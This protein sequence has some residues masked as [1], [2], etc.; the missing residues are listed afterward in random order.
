MKTLT[1]HTSLVGINVQFE[2]GKNWLE[3]K[4]CGFF[5]KLNGYHSLQE[6]THLSCTMG[7][8]PCSTM[9]RIYYGSFVI[10]ICFTLAIL[11]QL[12]GASFLYFY[13]YTAPQAKIRKWA[14][15]FMT[16]GPCLVVAGLGTWTVLTPD[17]G[18]LPRGWVQL[19]SS[20][21]GNSVLGYHTLN[22][23]Q[24]GWSFVLAGFVV[25]MM[26]IQVMIF[27]CC[28]RAHW[29]EEQ[30]DAEE[31]DAEQYLEYELIHSE[32][33][34]LYGSVQPDPASHAAMHGSI[35]SPQA[36]LYG[37]HEAQQLQK[38]LFPQQQWY[39]QQQ[40]QALQQQQKQ[41]E[42]EQQ[43]QQVDSPALGQQ[44]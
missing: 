36:S 27:P 4:I 22:G 35:Q 15:S 38:E 17:L 37:A 9:N 14:V 11:V 29:R 23:L 42:F 25:M 43:V 6:F 30:T 40:Q 44:I 12:G 28:F 21:T 31:E 13:W 5:D 18:E 20:F 7:G 2:C 39:Q 10:F 32:E 24:Y 41:N 3:D 16:A 34:P 26:L 19:M 1:I 8:V 33:A